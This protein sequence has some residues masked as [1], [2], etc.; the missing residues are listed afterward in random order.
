M[1]DSIH[2]YGYILWV[3]ATSLKG[4]IPGLARLI[5][6]TPSALYERQRALVR[7]G[8]LAPEEGRGPGSGVRATAPSIALLLISVLATDNLSET[9]ARTRGILSARPKNSRRCPLTGMTNFVDALSSLL[10]SQPKSSKIAEIAVWR[11][12]S[13]AMFRFTDGR[14]SEFSDET[15]ISSPVSVKATLDRKVFRSIADDVIAIL[16]AS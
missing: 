14:Q 13:R 12:S 4:L 6:S 2:Q 7:G 15:R 9:E 3:M 8:L 11:T 10:V 1:V 16:G 5:G